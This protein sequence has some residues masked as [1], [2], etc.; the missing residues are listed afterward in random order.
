MDLFTAFGVVE[1]MR[2]FESGG[3]SMMSRP[4]ASVS[5]RESGPTNVHEVDNR[6]GS[7]GAR[8]LRAADAQ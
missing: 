8:Q 4:L 7:L 2:F 3:A 6:N 1:L 5:E